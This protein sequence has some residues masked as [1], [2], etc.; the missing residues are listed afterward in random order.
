[1][2]TSVLLGINLNLH[3]NGLESKVQSSFLYCHFNLE[4]LPN[5]SK[6]SFKTDLSTL[7]GVK[8]NCKPL[9]RKET[10]ALQ[11]L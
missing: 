2:A 11:S 1:M 8:Q 10:S 4:V 5:F 6:S 9:K 7:L 3:R